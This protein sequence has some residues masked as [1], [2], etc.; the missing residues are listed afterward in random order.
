VLEDRGVSAATTPTDAA[1][2]ALVAHGLARDVEDDLVRGFEL[3]RIRAIHRSLRGALRP[4]GIIV[5][6]TP[7]LHGLAHRVRYALGVDFLHDP[8]AHDSMGLPHINLV[9]LRRSEVETTPS[10][11]F[12]RLNVSVHEARR[13]MQAVDPC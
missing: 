4:A 13:A 3:P 12:A 8:V 2:A 1:I 6:T 11:V 7:N 10:A 9:V 5:I